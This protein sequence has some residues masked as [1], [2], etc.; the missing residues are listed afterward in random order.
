MFG[1][2]LLRYSQNKTKVSPYNCFYQMAAMPKM[3]V[4]FNKVIRDETIWYEWK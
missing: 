3:L 1:S 4:K 2:K